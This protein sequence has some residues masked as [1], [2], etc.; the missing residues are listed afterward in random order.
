MVKLISKRFAGSDT[1]ATSTRAT[2]LHIVTNPLVYSKLQSEIDDAI[3]QGLV[4]NQTQVREA[5]KMPYL[6]SC[7]K[8]GLR[9]FP[10][11][12]SLH[13]RVTPPEGDEVCGFNV[14]G[15]V[16]IGFNLRAMQRDPVFGPDPEVFRPERWIEADESS[17]KEMDKVHELIFNYGS[18]KCLGINIAYSTLNKFFVEVRQPVGL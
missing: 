3:G 9:I 17:M 11:V 4:S 8:E 16:N 1:T 14:L 2:L 5:S 15:G 18:A 12:G 7:L 6:Q 13:Q 10:P